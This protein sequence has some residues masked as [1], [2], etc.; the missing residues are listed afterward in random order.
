MIGFV[1]RASAA[2]AIVLLALAPAGAQ[3]SGLTPEQVAVIEQ[4][5]TAALHNY[6]RLYTEKN[7]KALSS[8][9]FFDQWIQL[10]ANGPQLTGTEPADVARR[11]AANIQRLEEQGWVKSEYPKPIVCV[12]NAG[13]AI[14]SGEFMRYR[15]DGSVIS[16]NGTSYLFGKTSAGWRI[17]SFFGHERGK[18][19]GC[20]D[21]R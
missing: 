8:E 6:Y 4:E 20:D 17:V 21:G 13:T 2:G 11:F 19:I 3:E 12:I 7:N 10:G 16:V 5:V 15:Q 14:A 1:R 18:I 9:V